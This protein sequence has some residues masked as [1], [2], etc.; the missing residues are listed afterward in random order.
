MNARLNFLHNAMLIS[1]KC[2]VQDMRVAGFVVYG[3][4]VAIDSFFLSSSRGR[5][6]YGI[7]RDEIKGVVVSP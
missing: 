5:Q 2:S 6:K 4:C 3:N 7:K 1:C